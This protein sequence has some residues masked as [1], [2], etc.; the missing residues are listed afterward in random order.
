MHLKQIPL[1]LINRTLTTVETIANHLQECTS[2]KSLKQIHAQLVTH[3]L[4]S[5]NYLAVKL[6][7]CSKSLG[8]IAHARMI[9]NGLVDSANIF[10]WTA[11]ITAYSQHQ[12]VLT[13]EAI[14]IY[15][16]MLQHEIKPNSFTLSSVLKACSFLL[17]AREGSQIHVHALKLGLNS[18]AYVQTTLMDAYAKFGCIEA[19]AHLF[20]TMPVRNV[21]VCNAMIVCYTK[22]GFINAAR[23]IF[24]EMPEKDS[25]S[26]TAM[27][28]G[29]TN[30]GIMRTALELFTQMPKRDVAAWNALI[31][32]CSHCG[33]WHGALQLFNEMRL[34][35]VKPNQVT[36]AVVISVCGQLGDLELAKNFHSYLKE[37][38]MEINVH[39]FN[40]LIDTYAK[41]GC[42]DEAY[43]LFCRMPVRD[44]VSYN[45]MIAGFANHGHVEDALELFTELLESGERPDRITFLGVLTACDH[46]GMLDV[47]RRYFNSMTKDYAIEPTVDHYACMVDLLGRAGF[48]QEAYELVTTMVVDPHAGVW[49]ALLSA[50]RIYCNVKVGEIAAEKLFKI[51]PENLGNYVLLSNIYARA[52]MWE[53]VV[54]VRRW[55][56]ARGMPKT[57]GCSW[58]EVNNRVH[59]FL[60]GDINHPQCLDIYVILRHLSLQLVA[61]G[62]MLDNDLSCPSSSLEA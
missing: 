44:T 8:N 40:S 36:M 38:E 10:L 31:T 25:I 7:S 56:R 45:A 11:M 16:N 41:C 59:K 42:V 29:Y 28:S 19:A 39:M 49:G 12:S 46:A 27:I 15:N 47:G 32:G 14:L 57:G 58:I 61:D 52:Q 5:E 17:A 62:C 60:I 37:N 43:R 21:V 2:L 9:F 18:D 24:D 33:D 30:R 3:G 4:H 1:H 13:W 54:K 50:C 22:A 53:E 20:E 48:I 55:M 6:V 26:W 35:N 51:E 34:E 23:E